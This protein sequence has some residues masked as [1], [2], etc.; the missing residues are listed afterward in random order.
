MS[1]SM[2]D[3]D[4]LPWYLQS[5]MSASGKGQAK[6]A[7]QLECVPKI[8]KSLFISSFVNAQIFH[9]KLYAAEGRA[10][11]TSQDFGNSKKSE[12]ATQQDLVAGFSTPILVPR[13]PKMTTMLKESDEDASKRSRVQISSSVH[14]KTR[15]RSQEHSNDDVA[16][17]LVERRD[18]KRTKR[19]IIRP[20]IV[21]EGDSSNYKGRHTDAQRSRKQKDPSRKNTTHLAL[22]HGFTATNVGK[23]RLTV[24]PVLG[25]FRK[26]KAS[27]RTQIAKRSGKGLS[28]NTLDSKDLS[29]VHEAATFVESAFLGETSDAGRTHP[30]RP[31]SVTSTGVESTPSTPSRVLRMIQAS[32]S[33]AG[34]VSTESEA[35]CTAVRAGSEVWDIELEGYTLPSKL[36][37]SAA[38]L[39]PPNAVESSP[40]EKVE[41]PVTEKPDEETPVQ[42][43]SDPSS[44]ISSS[45]LA[46][47]QS[48]SQG[49]LTGHAIS[50]QKV[51]KYF[52]HPVADSPPK[53]DP[54]VPAH[55]TAPAIAT[56]FNAPASVNCHDV[57]F[58]TCLGLSDTGQLETRMEF[59]HFSP[60]LDNLASL[61]NTLHK[62]DEPAIL[63]DGIDLD[64]FEVDDDSPSDMGFYPERLFSDCSLGVT[65]SDDFYIPP[66]VDAPLLR[67][68]TEENADPRR[69]FMRTSPDFIT[70][71]REAFLD[72]PEE[73]RR[74][75]EAAECFQH[76]SPINEFMDEYDWEYE[77]VDAYYDQAS[78][79]IGVE[80]VFDE[81][82]DGM[83]SVVDGAA[84]AVHKFLQGR[85][86]LLGLRDGEET[87]NVRGWS[88]Y[89]SNAEAEVATHL[90]GHW[91]PQRL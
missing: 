7:L 37:S 29:S 34:S 20:A 71:D 74:D 61:D 5:S 53:I 22:M 11:W 8:D 16:R 42:L 23:N 32:P 80:S 30:R 91:L 81:D 36:S 18:K 3:R 77:G 88:N 58:P 15:K 85:E 40:W 6:L 12:Q 46:P 28:V 75:H 48:A 59:S 25:V 64:Q 26:G 63:S 44:H 9:A 50:V 55:H 10:I 73:F 47:S 4:L 31:S 76:E 87:T 35:E 41:I 90:K 84:A 49:G 38:E 14:K 19:E 39:K 33:A 17:R 79:E 54:N 45:S 86:I 68:D 27:A 62:Y 51:S 21:E 82:E 57:H 43:D 69:N 83:E 65:Y 56:A 60:P 89:I 70:D 1:Y 13:N 24:P 72:F 66:R 2:R 78:F 67:D 52:S